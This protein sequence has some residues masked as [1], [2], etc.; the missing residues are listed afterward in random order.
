MSKLTKFFIVQF[1]HSP[2]TSLYLFF[3]FIGPT[4]P[5]VSLSYPWFCNSE[6]SGLG[7]LATHPISNLEDQGLRFFWPL[8]FTYMTWVA[9]P[10]TYASASITLRVLG[11]HKLPLHD[12]AV[13][14]EEVFLHLGSKCSLQ[15][16]ALEC[17]EP[18][19]LPQCERPVLISMQNHRK[20]IVARRPVAV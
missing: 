19:V 18:V 15:N 7:S 5:C 14:F 3:F 16:S 17:S 9:L 13:D 20:N 8:P 12:E 10:G 2:V 4:T 11:A 1:L 6:F